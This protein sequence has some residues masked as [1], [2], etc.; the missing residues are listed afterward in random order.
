VEKIG[1]RV[2][3]GVV[4]V[5]VVILAGGDAFAY[6]GSEWE[7]DRTFTIDVKPIMGVSAPLARGKYLFSSLGCADC[8]GAD[9]A[10]KAMI[11]PNITS[12][13]G[14][15]TAAYTDADWNRT[16]RHG[17]KPNGN[18]L[19]V[20]PREDFARL[21]DADTVAIIAYAK[22]LPPVA[23]APMETNVPLA[24]VTARPAGT[25]HDRASWGDQSGRTSAPIIPHLV[26]TAFGHRSRIAVSSGHRSA[27]MTA[28]W[29]QSP[30]EQ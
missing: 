19:F 25:D 4:L 15:A 18:P 13:P 27:S 16:I 8:H 26:Q 29:W 21:T 28:L 23:G 6:F 3:V 20:M 17:V 9:G 30:V 12:G 22:S 5:A 14:G 2:L 11:A 24:D 1:F 10:G 7:I